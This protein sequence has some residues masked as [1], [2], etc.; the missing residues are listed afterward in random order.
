MRILVA[1]GSKHGST[2]EI[3][4]RI[5]TIIGDQMDAFVDCRPIGVV[6]NLY[7]YDAFVIGSSIYAERWHKNVNY[8]LEE[9]SKALSK[10]PVWLFASGPTEEGDAKTLVEDYV[11]PK[12]LEWVIQKIAPKEI[13]IFHGAIEPSKLTFVE[14]ALV[15]AVGTETG[16]FRDWASIDVWGSSIA[17]ILSQDHLELSPI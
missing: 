2:A 1:Y 7:R 5:A 10:K 11:V 9:N 14:K 12:N 8:F 6:T 4:K 13:M 17:E 15:R 16:D 3:A